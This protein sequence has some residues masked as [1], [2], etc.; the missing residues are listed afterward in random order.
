MKLEIGENL[1]NGAHIL[2]QKTAFSCSKRQM[3]HSQYISGLIRYNTPYAHVYT[4]YIS[5]A[6]ILANVRWAISVYVYESQA[7]RREVMRSMPNN[8][9]QYCWSHFDVFTFSFCL[10]LGV[11]LFFLHCS[12]HSCSVF[13]FFL[14][15]AVA[16]FFH[17]SSSAQGRNMGWKYVCQ[18]SFVGRQ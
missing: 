15:C 1:L 13:V 3:I 9:E 11:S 8:V 18:A 17:N 12:L 14:L 4:V 6:I 2:T 7:K 5:H 10:L 16:Y